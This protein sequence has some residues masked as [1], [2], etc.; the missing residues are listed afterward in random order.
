MMRPTRVRATAFSKVTLSLRVLGARPDGYHE[1]DALAVSLGQPQDS[2]EAQ[3]ISEPGVQ[4]ELAGEERSGALPDGD[5]NLAAQA[6]DRVLMRAGR[7]ALG[8]RLTLRKR[9]PVGGGLGGGSA[10]AAATLVAVRHLLELELDD[11]VLFELAAQLGSDVPF[12]LHGGAARMRGRGEQL[13][14]VKV[15]LGIPFLVVMAPFGLATP[16]VYRMWDEMGGP[17]STRGVTPPRA[18]AQRLGPL[19]NDLEPAAEA[20]DQRVR[21]LREEIEEVAGRD[22]LLAGSGSTY[23]VPVDIDGRRLP[24]LAAEM[25][26]RLRLPVMPAATVSR[27]V[28]LEA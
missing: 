22:A 21:E 6:A 12:C 11:D 3:V 14:P 23:V 4:I 27:G 10:D 28:R 25:G 24:D 15:P 13:E 19:F 9:I 16:D 5:E 1:I 8:V 17:E 26:Q 2:L 7:Q 20:L 18:L